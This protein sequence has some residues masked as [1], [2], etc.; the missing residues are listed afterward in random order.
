MLAQPTLPQHRFRQSPGEALEAADRY[1]SLDP[2][3]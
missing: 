1:P 2:H 3:D